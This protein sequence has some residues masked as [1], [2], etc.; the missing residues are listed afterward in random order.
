MRQQFLAPRQGA[1][2]ARGRARWLWVERLED[3]A[4]LTPFMVMNTADSGSG[5]LRQAIFDSNAAPAPAGS[6]NLIEF[7]IPTSDPGYDATTQTWAIAPDT[8]LPTVTAPVF[9]NGYTQP[10][11][12]PNTNPPGQ[13]KNTVLKVVLTDLNTVVAVNGLTISAGNS[14]VS[15]LVIDG[16]GIG[17]DLTQNGGD[18][19]A[20]NF[21]GTDVTGAKRAGSDIGLK[22]DS[23]GNVTVG[24]AAPGAGN[25]ISGNIVGILS[26]QA[27]PTVTGDLVQGNFIGTDVTGTHAL[28]AT[29]GMELANDSGDT[30]GGTTP[31]SGNLISGNTFHGISV[32]LGSQASTDTVIEGN[33]FGTDITGRMGLS[34][35]FSAASGAGVELIG[36]G[37]TI[38]GAAAG[39]GNI[40]ADNGFNGVEVAQGANNLIS[41]NAIF[42]N[43]P[44]GILVDSGANPGVTAPVLTTATPNPDGSVTVQGTLQNETAGDT[45]TIELFAN[46]TNDPAGQE[47]GQTFLTS[48]TA[49]TDPSGA[50]TFSATFTPPAGEPFLTATATSSQN[51]TS[52]FSNSLGT[53][54]G[55]PVDLLLSEAVDSGPIAVGSNLGY[56][57]TVANQGTTMA[58]GVTL[59]HM[60]PA[61]ATFVSAV[62]SQGTATQN[63]GLVTAALG[64]IA[65]GANATVRVV[66]DLQ[67]I[68]SMVEIAASI[69]AAQSVLHPS[70]GVTS[71]PI[72]VAPAPPTNVATSV[73]IALGGSRPVS[74]HWTDTLPPGTVAT[75]NVYRSETPS[76][77]G[78]TPY[79]TGVAAN[80]YTDLTAVPGHVYYYQVTAVA[81]G[82][83]SQHSAETLGTILVAPTITG[84][85]YY[86]LADGGSSVV[87]NWTYPAA[88]G[89]A[90]TFN[91]YQSTYPGGEGATPYQTGVG[92]APNQQNINA[93]TVSM[94]SL[95]ASTSYYQIS[96]VVEGH[97]GPRSSEFEAQVPGLAAPILSLTD[98]GL[99][100]EGEGQIDLNWTNPDP[101]A[102]ALTYLVYTSPDSNFDHARFLSYAIRNSDPLTQLPGTTM[103]YWVAAATEVYIGPVSN[104]VSHIVPPLTAAPF[105]SLLS[106][107]VPE[108]N[109]TDVYLDWTD[110]YPNSRLIQYNIYRST[111]QGGEGSTP[112]YVD[113]DWAPGVPLQYLDQPVG[114]TYYF[115]VSVFVPGGA[116]AEGPRSNELAVPTTPAYERVSVQ[117]ILVQF[118]QS[119]RKKASNDVMLKFS[120]ALDAAD[121][122]NLAAYH[123]VSLGKLNKKT[124]QHAI[125]AVKL[126]SAVYNASQNTV[127]LAI[128]GKLPN[129]QLELSVNTSSVLDA[130]GQ[131]IA[132]TSGQPGSTLQE[133]FGKKGITL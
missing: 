97:E 5:S 12:A 29:D 63:A 11:A 34:N 41:R 72:D 21:I 126:T 7:Q 70:Q 111:A 27:T 106:V 8:T 24:G 89:T 85:Q 91:V 18:T 71:I 76:G 48:T 81:G 23:V 14:T 59:T 120:G 123:L 113:T 88:V 124:G 49:M 119:A 104:P 98:N 66:V 3:R 101:T 92:G 20:G 84:A 125:K 107:P 2:Y 95:P 33:L 44:G 109:R 94:E 17:I 61:A 110:P 43:T 79:A 129:Q 121:A 57:F 82:L 53:P 87:L 127:T 77:E 16:F 67:A 15:G 46:A 52:A 65:G 4:L 100:S 42:G 54:V 60:L 102:T 30:I 114:P 108:Y 38:G 62:P 86:G 36:S 19:I 50:G 96:A 32:G 22:M 39:A 117:N 83:E 132:G 40:I 6:T 80:Q 90:I 68:G 105:L 64:S 93:D 35:S 47:E 128:K 130:S 31:G 103:Y 122:Q 118:E 10:G 78:T 75:F 51:T 115:Q 1:R 25:V 28:S 112:Y 69:A 74:V 26:Q 56:T 9:I 13:G 99:T 45:I 58:T 131:P 73:Q 55:T 116:G 37:N 133:T